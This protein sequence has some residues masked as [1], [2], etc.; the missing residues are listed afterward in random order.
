MFSFGAPCTFALVQVEQ[1]GEALRS[2]FPLA[3][4]HL[5]SLWAALKTRTIEA[6]ILVH[7]QKGS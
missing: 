1:A 5:A 4:L 3:N 2:K 7:H 6:S